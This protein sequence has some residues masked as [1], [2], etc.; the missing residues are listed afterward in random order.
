M[1]VVLSRGE[2]RFGCEISVSTG[3]THEL[4]NVEKCLA[5]GFDLVFVVS[6]RRRF[7]AEVGKRIDETLTEAERDR[8]RV[9]SPEDLLAW[10]SNEPAREEA[11]AGYTVTTRFSGEVDRD[12]EKR[13]ERLAGVIGRSLKRI[14]E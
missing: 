11:V 13:R 2:E 6:L 1:D 8:V 4:G 7:L 9:V 3:A 10:L 14:K 12:Q 5:A